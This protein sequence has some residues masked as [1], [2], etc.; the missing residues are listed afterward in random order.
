MA[1]PSAVPSD[2][3]G[4]ANV[5][6]LL[7]TFHMNIEEK[8]IPAAIRNAGSRVFHFHA[9]END[10]GMPGTGHV[11]WQEAV[12]ALRAIRYEGP[13]VIE[14]FT[15]EI[16]EIARAVSLWRPLAPDQDS[17]GPGRAAFSAENLQRLR[18]TSGAGDR[19]RTG[20]NLVGNEILYQLSYTRVS[21]ARPGQ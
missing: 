12:S 14:A 13:V 18:D 10:R 17:L 3:V 11:E 16:T 7:D 1:P 15:A 6:F 8:D 5:D 19:T 4:A 2:R 20:D 9:C 21:K